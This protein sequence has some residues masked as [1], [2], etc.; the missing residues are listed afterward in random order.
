M[1][2]LFY[3]PGAASLAVHA[4]L[5]E[6]DAPHDLVKVDLQVQRT[7]DYLRLNPQGTVPTLVIDGLAHRESAALLLL[8][9]ERHPQA[10]LAPP[11]GAPGRAEWLQWSVALA[12][13]LGG[14]Y[15]LW[16]YPQDLGLPEHSEQ[17]RAPVQ[18]ILEAAFER[19]ES[20]LVAHGPYL[21]GERFSTADY[22]LC[23]YMRWSRAMPKPATE[24]PAL[25]RLAR[26]VVARP[27]WRNAVA[28][29]GLRGWHLDGLS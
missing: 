14:P 28:M 16:F 18:R 11:P 3:A 10:D 20:H 6:V 17:T 25:D 2:T 26:L 12:T 22:Q 4:A 8:L 19:I 21:L 24:W 7:E 1:Y 15:R 23:M 9:A 13:S 5:H 27:A 29:E